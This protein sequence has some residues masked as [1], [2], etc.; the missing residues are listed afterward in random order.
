MFINREESTFYYLVKLPL[1]ELKRFIGDLNNQSIDIPKSRIIGIARNPRGDQWIINFKAGLIGSVKFIMRREVYGDTIEYRSRDG[2]LSLKFNLYRLNHET[3]MVEYYIKAIERASII[4]RPEIPLLHQRFI[5]SLKA[6]YNDVEITSI[7]YET[8][9]EI[10]GNIVRSRTKEVKAPTQET[11]YLEKPLIGADITLGTE[12]KRM[13][14]LF[15]ESTAMK[16]TEVIPV[17]GSRQREETIITKVAESKPSP[18]CDNCLLFDE[19][20]GYC[21]LLIRKIEDINTPLC[22]G[23]SFIGR[24]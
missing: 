16:V 6:L 12:E 4:L 17:S 18:R 22:K 24:G 2:D 19:S 7:T 10:I 21:T 8:Y 5:E 13:R 15:T 3:T 23:E 20:T 14:E 9:L 1:E 11:K